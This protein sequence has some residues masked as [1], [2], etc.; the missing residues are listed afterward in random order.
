MLVLQQRKPRENYKLWYLI[1][2]L[3]AAKF[4]KVAAQATGALAVEAD[5]SFLVTPLKSLPFK[6]GN[7]INRGLEGKYAPEFDLTSD[8]FYASLSESQIQ[9]KADVEKVSATIQFQHALGNS[10]I[11]GMLTV[12]SGGLIAISMNDTSIIRP[13]VRGA[14]VSVTQLDQKLLLNAPGS[15]TGLKIVYSNMLLFYVPV[16]GAAEKIRLVGASQGLLSVRS[17]N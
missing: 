10:N 11:L 5:T 6:Y 12:E 13:K 3:P 1:D 17:I 7:T 14:A 15:A 4:P 9:Q 2:L 16:A 8:E